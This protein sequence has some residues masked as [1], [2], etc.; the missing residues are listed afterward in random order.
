MTRRTY[1]ELGTLPERGDRIEMHPAT[2]LFM[3]GARY[4]TVTGFSLTPFDRI[5]FTLDKT[6]ETVWADSGKNILPLD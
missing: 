3:R 2:D 5:H 6:G 1:A 4:G